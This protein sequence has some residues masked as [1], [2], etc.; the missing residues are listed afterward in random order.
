M[1]ISVQL[2]E[3]L[4]MQPNPGRAALELLVIAGYQS[5]ALSHFLAS[6]MLELNRFE[7]ERFL[8]EKKIVAQ[9]YDENEWED[10]MAIARQIRA[11][12]LQR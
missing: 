12:G 5:G 4:A 11:H 2:P 8:Q 6:Q 7:F 9:A 3:D 10:D 1:E